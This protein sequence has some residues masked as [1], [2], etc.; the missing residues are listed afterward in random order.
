MI[1]GFPDKTFGGLQVVVSP[2]LVRYIVIH[3]RWKRAGGRTPKVRTRSWKIPGD[4]IRMDG[5]IIMHPTT[6]KQLEAAIRD[7]PGGAERSLL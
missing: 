7:R 6:F 3:K 4:M 2:L 5:N 1:N